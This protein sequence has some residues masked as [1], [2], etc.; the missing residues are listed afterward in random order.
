VL[1]RRPPSGLISTN[2]LAPTSWKN[3][4]PHGEDVI[5]RCRSY[6][7]SGVD[8]TASTGARQPFGF[9]RPAFGGSRCRAERSGGRAHCF[10]GVRGRPRGA[11][12]FGARHQGAPKDSGS[13]HGQDCRGPARAGDADVFVSGAA[14]PAARRN[15]DA[16]RSRSR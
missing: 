10:G 3:P 5:S 1:C 13:R 14:V 9:D 4:G 7:S 15:A 16:R 12:G 11:G 6:H 8:P 2:S